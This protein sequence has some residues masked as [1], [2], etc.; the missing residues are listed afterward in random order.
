MPDQVT[1]SAPSRLH[2]GLFSVG[3]TGEQQDFGGAGLMIKSPVTRVTA[4]K[5]VQFEIE[6]LGGEAAGQALRAW[7]DRLPRSQT[8]ALNAGSLKE[9]GVKLSIESIPPRHSGFGSGT[10][11]ALSAATAVTQLF[12]LPTLSPEEL[13][14]SVGRGKR[15][16]IGSHG[17]FRGGFLVDRGKSPGSSLAPLD[18]QCEFP[19]SWPI[20]TVILNDVAGLFGTQEIHAFRELAPTPDTRRNQLIEIVRN[21][22]IPG[23][24]QQNYSPFADG[25]FE[26]GRLSGLMFSDIQEGAYNGP[27]VEKLV[28]QIRNFGI[29]AVGQSSWGPCVFAIAR[30]DKQARELV[31]FLQSTYGRRCD[32]ERTQADNQGAR[33]VDVKPQSALK[34]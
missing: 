24:F 22:I 26:L 11:L 30:N 13:V 5:S 9:L 29:G 32:V 14:A 15:S 3:S 10:Q 18:F 33:V 4:T 12:A 8:A 1:I 27:E 21:Q 34:N 23:I 19:D 20:V 25:I 2:F 7:F 31:T 6:G 16:A 28:N 17:F